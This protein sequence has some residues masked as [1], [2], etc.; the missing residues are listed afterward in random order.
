LLTLWRQFIPLSMSDVTM[1]MAVPLVNMGLGYGT[2]AEANLAAAGVGRTVAV[3][4]E[5]PIIMVLHA[6]NVLA[7]KSAARKAFWRLV[8]LLTALL[9][10]GICVLALPA[11]FAWVAARLLGLQPDL[12][13]RTHTVLLFLLVWPALIGWR[14]YFQG[15]LIHAD[16]MTTI[17]IGGISRLV[18]TGVVLALGMHWAWDGPILAGAAAISGVVVETGLIML[19][20]RHFHVSERPETV[21]GPLWGTPG[22][23]WR[24]YRPL[25]AVMLIVWGARI[26]LGGIIARAYD[27]AIALAVWAAASAII[28]LVTNASFMVQQVVIRNRLKTPLRTMMQFVI[29]SGLVGSAILLLIGATPQGARLLALLVGPQPALIQQAIP[30]VAVCIPAPLV[31]AFMATAQGWLI[32]AGHTIRVNRATWLGAVVQ[33]GTGLIGVAAGMP[34]GTVAGLATLLSLVA[35]TA[36]LWGQVRLTDAIPHPVQ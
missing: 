26:G 34:G 19:A 35:E 8:L 15:L 23:V 16:H 29:S 2:F 11:V 5:S 32:G 6:A 27:S 30:V 36:W 4:F 25:A 7:G 24:F 21:T 3:L 28:V 14:R 22:Q 18:G 10:V 17:G 20:A 31:V 12:A 1:A 13:A 9:T 33:I